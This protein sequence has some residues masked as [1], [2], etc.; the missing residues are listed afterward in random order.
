MTLAESANWSFP[1]GVRFGAGRIAEIAD[2]CAAA[3]MDRPLVVTDPGMVELPVLA[4]LRDLLD[5]A[6]V[7]H[8]L[9]SDL[10]PN[11]LGS[12]VDR[13][14]DAF[15]A[16]DHDGVIAFGGGSA[17]DVGKLVAFMAGQSRPLWDFEDV[18]DNWTRADAAAIAP[19]V[20]VPTTAGTGSEVGRAGV[21][22]NEAEGRKFVAFHPGMLARVVICDPELTV[23]LPPTLTVGTGIDAFSHC[24]EAL[25]APG[26]HPMAD[27]IAVEGCRLV[28]DHLPR[29]V[30]DPADVDSRGHMMAAAAMG[31][32]AFQK[33]LG[34][35]HAIS[36]PVSVR[37]HTHHGMTN[38]V[39]MPYVLEANGATITDRLDRLAAYAGIDGGAGGLQRH[40]LRWRDI[41]DVP[42]TLADLGADVSDAAAIASDAVKEPPAAGNPREL[43]EDLAAEIYTAACTGE[44]HATR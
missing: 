39:L 1:T 27:G 9:F 5:G 20:A 10:R 26:Y 21:V 37:W 35:I 30:A 44:L 14:V 29:V 23:G 16:G 43:T 6:S 40:I 15:R 36:H 28:I 42:H 12:D 34:A 33:G 24:L 18:G 3:G 7:V 13:G 38:A 17:L 32:V 8:G 31:A 2:A 22:I 4:T 25:C 19:V 11:P 41:L